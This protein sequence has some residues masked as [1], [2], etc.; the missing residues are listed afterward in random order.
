VTRKYA[1]RQMTWFRKNKRV[2]WFRTDELEKIRDLLR[3]WLQNGSE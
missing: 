3:R 1:K 2:R